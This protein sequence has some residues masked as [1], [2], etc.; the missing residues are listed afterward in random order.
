MKSIL[1]HIET[2]SPGMIIS[3]I[4]IMLNPTPLLRMSIFIGDSKLLATVIIT[5][6][7]NTNV[8]SYAIRQMN[9]IKI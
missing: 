3:P 7:A 2:R 8:T 5:S 9:I 1:M 4:P 6:E